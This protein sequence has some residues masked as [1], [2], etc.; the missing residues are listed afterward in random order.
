MDDGKTYYIPALK[1]GGCPERGLEGVTRRDLVG[2]LIADSAAVFIGPLREIVQ[3]RRLHSL[4]QR[5]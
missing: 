4:H 1:S 3:E 2:H 5:G